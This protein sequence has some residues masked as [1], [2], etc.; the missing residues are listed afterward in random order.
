MII[1]TTSNSSFDFTFK[2]LILTSNEQNVI[3][4][5]LLFHILRVKN[6]KRWTV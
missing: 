1:T 2:L 4:S 3:I 6:V 5:S